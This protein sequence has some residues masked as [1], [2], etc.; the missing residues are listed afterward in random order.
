MAVDPDKLQN[1]AVKAGIRA[2]KRRHHMLS[3]EE[4]LALKV[5]VFP[6]PLRILCGI[7]GVAFMAGAYFGW[8]SDS[9]AFQWLMGCGGLLQGFFAMFGIRRTL[10][11]IIDHM[12]ADL[13]GELIGH[14]LG[15]I[16]DAIDF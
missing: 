15:A 12:S 5:Q 7:G 2:A 9:N 14:A 6:A 8:P 10:S 3:E 16:A 11:G 13:V 1:R 4:L